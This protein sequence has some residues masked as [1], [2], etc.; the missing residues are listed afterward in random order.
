MNPPVNGEFP[1]CKSITIID[2]SKKDEESGQELP[3]YVECVFPD[4]KNILGMDF[5]LANEIADTMVDASEL[6]IASRGFSEGNFKYMSNILSILMRP[7]GEIYNSDTSLARADKFMDT[8]MD[9]VWGVFF[10]LHN[11][12]SGLKELIQKY[13]QKVEAIQKKAMEGL[14]GTI[15]SSSQP[16]INSTK[17]RSLVS[18]MS[19][20]CSNLLMRK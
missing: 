11:S 2:G 7:K 14:D 19:M 8:K 3:I 20:K 5:P 18:K 10:Y 17:L 12:V 6:Y 1:E 13:S 15:S 16:T 4:E 9:Q